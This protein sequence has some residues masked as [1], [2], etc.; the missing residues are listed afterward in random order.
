MDVQLSKDPRMIEMEEL[1]KR[2]AEVALEEGINSW[3]S[4]QI[5]QKLDLLLNDIQ[6]NTS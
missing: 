6:K 3:E 4:V 5:S 2:M 1:R